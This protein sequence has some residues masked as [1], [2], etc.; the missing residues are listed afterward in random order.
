MPSHL[1]YGEWTQNLLSSTGVE[2]EREGQPPPG[3]IENLESPQ[4]ARQEMAAA[5]FGDQR[6]TRRSITLLEDFFAHP[7]SNL[8]QACG[9]NVNKTKAAYEFFDNFSVDFQ[10]MLCSHRQATVARLQGQALILA[11][12]D[13]T[14]LDH[15]PPRATEGTGP[16]GSHREPTRGLLLHSTLTFTLEG[17]PLGFLDAQVWVR[18]P[19]EFGKKHTRK[20]RPIE[21]KES[22]KWLQSFQACQQVQ[23]QLPDTRIINVGDREA[24]IYEL[25]ALARSEAGHPHLLIRVTQDRRVADAEA[26]HLWQRMQRQPVA[27]S[28]Q[29]QVPR[30]GPQPP[31]TA[32]L[33]VRFAPVELKAPARLSRSLP[34][35]SL[36]AV[37]AEEVAAPAGV[38]PISW[39]LLTTW[40]VETTEQ[41]REVLRWYGL[42]F[43][44]ELFHKVLKSGCRAEQR[45]LKTEE[46]LERCLFF[47]LVVAWRIL[48]LTK[49][50]RQVPALPASA[51][52]EPEEWQA[53][54]CFTYQ[55]TQLP[56]QELSLP[57][58]IRLVAKL[59]GFLGRK[60]DKDPGPTT[61]WRGL[62]RLHDITAAYKLFRPRPP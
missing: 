47:D 24:D 34:S 19:E 15:S 42:R 50:G 12:Q 32:S 2:T 6:L 43:Q 25:M 48:L 52:F 62:V 41:A 40:P 5:A 61:I 7:M 60:R 53:L 28:F 20:Q 35:L 44:I 57:Q 13:T 9:G 14:T 1:N 37:W 58:A 26:G 38:E 18:A 56:A 17:V 11:V 46:R 31:R 33:E 10:E 30:K 21:D 45:Q 3:W 55:T 4:W 8:P 16:V 29:A 22:Y 51:V 59:G 36:G 39:M 54:Y 49:L 23:A 27:A